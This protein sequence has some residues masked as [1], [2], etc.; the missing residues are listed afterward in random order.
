[1]KQRFPRR[2]ALSLL[3]LAALSPRAA[4]AR[5]DWPTKPVRIVVPYAPGGVSDAVA[6]LLGEHLRV[7]LGQ[8]VIV[9]N[10]PGA[11]ATVGIDAVA[12]SAPD[13]HTLAFSAISPLT[14]NPHLQRVPYDPLKDLI[15]VA[16][17]M[18]S[19]ILFVATAAFAGSS[20]AD[21]IARA[22]AHPDSLS[23]ATSGIG[24]VGHV[25]LAQIGRKSG[26]R[27]NHVPYKGG[28]Q[29]INDALGGQFELF[30]INPGPAVNTAI[31]QGK[32]RVLAVAAPQR[33]P[34]MIHVPTFIELGYPDANLGSVFGFFA[35]ARTS[36]AVLARINAEVNKV[37]ADKEVLERL[38]KLDGLASPANMEA[39]SARVQHEYDV[40]ERIVKDA[41]ILVE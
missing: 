25:M 28:G 2:R 4:L 14:L 3:A 32:L 15:P 35:P 6:R 24:S 19:P 16:Q 26:V 17:V 31:A 5:D 30:T 33:L 39:F 34:S 27:F 12:K 23:V 18:Y 8:P 9:E 37:L 13:G 10:R 11:G 36:P 1:M 38:A 22:R 41:G 21:V 29:V 7:V 20:F 40:N